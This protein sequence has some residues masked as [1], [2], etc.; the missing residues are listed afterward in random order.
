MCL[1]VLYCT[2]VASLYFVHVC[3]LTHSFSGLAYLLGIAGVHLPRAGGGG[4]GGGVRE[5][6]F[7]G[8]FIWL[9]LSFEC[10]MVEG[11]VLRGYLIGEAHVTWMHD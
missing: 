7:C 9:D 3:F 4:G 8:T 11:S 10:Y 5:V 2:A 1:V 6:S